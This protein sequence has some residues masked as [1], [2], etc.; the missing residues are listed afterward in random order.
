M[1]PSKRDKVMSGSTQIWFGTRAVD[2][3]GAVSGTGQQ[4]EEIVSNDDFATRTLNTGTFD[5]T[6]SEWQQLVAFMGT[7]AQQ[8][9]AGINLTNGVDPGAANAVNTTGDLRVG[10]GVTAQN[11]ADLIGGGRIGDVSNLDQTNDAVAVGGFARVS[12]TAVGEAAFDNLVAGQNA[13]AFVTF[14]NALGF[15]LV[16]RGGWDINGNATRLNDGDSVDLT[17]AAGQILTDVSF[18]VRVNGAAGATAEIFLDSDGQT[19]RTGTTLG[20]FVQDGS[21]G[22]L[23]LGFLAEGAKVVVDYDD[24][25][26]TINGVA[27]VGDALSFFSTFVDNGIANVTFGSKVVNASGTGTQAAVGWSADDV[28]LTFQA[29]DGGAGPGIAT[30]WLSFDW[31]GLGDAAPTGLL[32]G[33]MYAYYDADGDNTLGASEVAGARNMGQ[34][35]TGNTLTDDPGDALLLP[36]LRDDNPIQGAGGMQWLE[37]YAI[38]AKNPAFPTGLPI[39]SGAQYGE[40]IGANVVTGAGPDGRFSLAVNTARNPADITPGG[41]NGGPLDIDPSQIGTLRDLGP[42]Y[43]NNG[44]ILGFS[45]INNAVG[46]ASFATGAK[47]SFAQGADLTPS[48]NADIIVRLY[49]NTVLLETVTY[50]ITGTEASEQSGFFLVADN[51]GQNFNRMEIEAAGSMDGINVADAGARFVVTDVDIFI[52]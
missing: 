49:N 37:M 23:S 33:R 40:H 28:V 20:S 30:A 34:M 15:G 48:T 7:A 12:N 22:E 46:A 42:Q 45:L 31:F 24:Q 29:D 13:G 27:F 51:L 9:A 17:V 3:T 19:I 6:G 44:E 39:V 14:S 2:F 35:R 5:F 4:V 16:N 47:I 43:V 8:A 21:A 25:T 52:I 32:A 26:I 11:I 36:A 18:T 41:P 38:G 10:N 50:N 1:S